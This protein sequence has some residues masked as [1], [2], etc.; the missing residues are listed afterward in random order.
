MEHKKFPLRQL[1]L[2]YGFYLRLGKFC[3][4]APAIYTFGKIG[5]WNALVMK[6][7]G[8]SLFNMSCKMGPFSV[9][10]TTAVAIKL[11]NI[12]KFI[13]Q[14]GLLYRDTKPDNFLL[15]P[16]SSASALSLY[17]IGSRTFRVTSTL[18]N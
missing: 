17:I 5:P 18:S 12:F 11:L 4:V 2:E 15:G 13:H 3:P 10:C 6:L 16:A 7:L 8:P 14:K 1:Y 9:C